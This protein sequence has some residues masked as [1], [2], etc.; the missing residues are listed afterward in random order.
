[1][2]GVLVIPTG[3]GARIGG[4]AGDG[5]PVAKL[6]AACCDTLITHPNV[7]NA[8]DINEMTDFVGA[9]RDAVGPDMNLMVD[10]NQGWPVDL[11][12]WSRSVSTH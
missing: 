7:V 1:M 8:S 4:N 10:A 11:L 2:I 9:A 5:N 6:M 3:L 12:E